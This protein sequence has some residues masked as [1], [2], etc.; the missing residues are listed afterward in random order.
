M[1]KLI[2]SLYGLKQASK[3]WNEKFDKVITSAGFAINDYDR[4]VYSKMIGDNC[5]IL[6]LYV[7]D[8]LIFGLDIN[9][10]YETKSYLS[11]NFDMKY[12]YQNQIQ[13]YHLHRDTKLHIYHQSFCYTHIYHNH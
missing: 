5:V 2:K 8:I 12:L 7:D 3:Q 13:V 9:V 10:I 6:C 11:K 4:C 1:C